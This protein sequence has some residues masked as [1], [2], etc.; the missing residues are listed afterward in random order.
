[1]S[2]PA[3]LTL[4]D[5]IQSHRITS[6]IYVAAKLGI[7]DMLL[8]GAKPLDDIAASTGADRQALARLLAALS[9]IGLCKRTAQDRYTLTETGAALASTARPSCK[10][11]AIFEAEMLQRSWSGML[12]TIMTGK[13]AAQL[14]GFN[15]SFDMMAGAP[16][17]VRMFNAAMADLTGLVTA[18]LLEAYDFGRIAH[19]MDVGGGSGELIGAVATRYPQVRG[20]VFDL[21]RCGEAANAHLAGLGIADRVAFQ[22]GDFFVSVP[23]VADAIILK[24]VIHDWDDQRSDVILR[25][26]RLALPANGSLL[27]VERIMPEAPMPCDADRSHAFSD[28]NMLRGP[29]GRERT[30]AQYRGLLMQA[31]F[32]TTSIT[33]IGRFAVIE[34][35]PV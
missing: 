3:A 17:Q 21:V 1:M 14:R 34:A 31:G 15:S 22:A 7:A 16:D 26:C 30:E 8:D 28:L 23:A 33:P 12:E 35:V 18:D 10:A 24:S 9:T 13:T 6:A 32:R 20:T 11:W 19:L 2:S 29:G 27:L 4:L 5:L 25:N